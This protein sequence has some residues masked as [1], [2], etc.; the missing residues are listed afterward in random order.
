MPACVA[1]PIPYQS[2]NKAVNRPNACKVVIDGSVS[3]VAEACVSRNSREN[4]LHAGPLA[5]KLGDEPS[6]IP[7]ST[8]PG[9][10]TKAGRERTPVD[11][12]RFNNAFPG[13]ATGGRQDRRE[14]IML[15]FG[16]TLTLARTAAM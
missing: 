6:L 3:R 7:V 13:G 12:G 9:Y 8:G 1:V 11:A 15:H 2:N 10:R 14:S 5:W 16:K 4:A